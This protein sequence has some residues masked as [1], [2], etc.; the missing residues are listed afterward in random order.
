MH[1]DIAYGIF[2]NS[3]REKHRADSHMVEEIDKIPWRKKLADELHTGV[4][5]TFL[6]EELSPTL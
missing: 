4:R 5:K 3:K 6:G 2:G 1:R